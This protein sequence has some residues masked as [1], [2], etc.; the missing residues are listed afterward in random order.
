[1]LIEGAITAASIAMR[2]VGR[3]VSSRPIAGMARNAVVQA[4]MPWQAAVGSDWSH[5]ALSR[6]CLPGIRSP[7]PGASGMCMPI[8]ALPD[9]AIAA[10]GERCLLPTGVAHAA[11]MP[12]S[13]S[14]SDKTADSAAATSG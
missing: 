2:T 6:W 12:A 7:D 11:P 14:W 3:G 1:M 10:A 4:A 5:G 13:T 9:V 8:I